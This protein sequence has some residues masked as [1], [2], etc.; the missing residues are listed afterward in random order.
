[1]RFESPVQ[2]VRRMPSDD[3]EL[4]GTKL[5]KD[6]MIMIFLGSANRDPEQF[7][8]ADKFDITRKENKHLA[9]SEGIHYC[10]G[11]SLAR[12]EGQIA[13]RQLF[14]RLPNLKLATDRVDFKMPFALRGPRSLP[15]K[16]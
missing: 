3:L 8:N 10:L 14:N 2:A 5:K 13:L 12:K 6:D 16:W 7:P 15:V 4:A 1:L 9:F 11:A